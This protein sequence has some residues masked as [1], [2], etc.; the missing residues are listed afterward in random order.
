MPFFAR[1]RLQSMIDDLAAKLAASEKSADLLRRLEGKDT[2]NALAAEVEVA[3]LWAISTVA[4]IDI[5]PRFPGVRQVPEALSRDL[6]PSGPS[7][8]EVTAL[9]DD[10]FSGRRA[11]ERTA[12]KIVHA[13]NI[14]RKGAGQRL[15]FEFLERRTSERGRFRRIRCVDPKFEVTPYFEE[16]LR[17]WLFSEAPPDGPDRVRLTHGSTDVVITRYNK[18][19]VEVGRVWSSMPAVTYDIEDNPV[20]KSLEEKAY[21][22][23]HVSSSILRCVF[24]F[25]AGSQLLRYFHSQGEM[26]VRGSRIVPHA[27]SKLSLDVVCVFSPYRRPQGV[28]EAPGERPVHWKVETFDR[29]RDILSSEYDKLNRVAAA[30]PHPRF[31]GYQARSLHRQGYYDYQKHNHHLTASMTWDHGTMEGAIRISVRQL[32]LLLAGRIT[33]E[34]FQKNN[35]GDLGNQVDRLLKRGCTISNIIFE[36]KGID[37]DD[38][39]AVLEFSSDP[40]AMT[41]RLSKES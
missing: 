1:R 24:L 25:D 11:M 39:I 40:S 29:R 33:S 15:T 10:V 14:I 5:Y 3:S 36:S 22:L 7:V 27:L 32:Q 17:D 4:E 12:Q 31:E 28:L 35:F 16:A 6:F 21:Q 38:D 9:H 2:Q 26:E 13:A 30:L 34:E 19:V 37:N 41:L 8:I 23:K 20:Y 18:P